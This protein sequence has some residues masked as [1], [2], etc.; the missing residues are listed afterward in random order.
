VSKFYS[1]PSPKIVSNANASI[2]K[3]AMLAKVIINVNIIPP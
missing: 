1:L 2:A 3:I